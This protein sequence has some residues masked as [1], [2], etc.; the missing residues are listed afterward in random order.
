VLNGFR[1]TLGRGRPNIARLVIGV[2]IGAIVGV[3]LTPI[4][5]TVLIAGARAA[6]SE[7]LGEFPS[8]ASS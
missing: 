4:V 2:V 8:Q 3:A 1:R 7:F 6:A 5:A